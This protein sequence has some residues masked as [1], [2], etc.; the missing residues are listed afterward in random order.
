MKA[1]FQAGG[2]GRILS[3]TTLALVRGLSGTQSQQSGVA[4]V[5]R[6]DGGENIWLCEFITK[7]LLLESIHLVSRAK[8]S[9]ACPLPSSHMTL[10]ESLSSHT[11]F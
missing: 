2:T 9:K 8:T 1:E 10:P 7:H 3:K 11:R 5:S 4:D 6:R